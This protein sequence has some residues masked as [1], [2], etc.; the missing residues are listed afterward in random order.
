MKRA[1]YSN[2][3]KEFLK[4]DEL[5]I[6]GEIVSNDQ[7]SAQDLQK[8]T[9]KREI[10]ILKRE[11][12]YFESGYI[13]FEYTIPRI[14]NR[15]DNVFIY[16]GIIFLLEFKVGEKT[17]PNYAIEQVTDY[18]LDLNSFHKESHNKLLV[19]ILVSTEAAEEWQEIKEIRKNILETH[20]CNELNIHNY[21]QEIV[22]NYNKDEFNPIEWVN[23]I[24]MPTPTIIQAAQVLYNGHNVK[25]IS[26][27]DASAINLNKTTEEIN[28]IID[29]S[30]VNNRKS[31]CFITGV[32]GAGKTLAG[33]NIA[34]ER[35]KIDKDEHAVFLSGNGPLVDVLREA[36]ARDDVE[37]NKTT[38]KDSLRKAEEFI[39]KI[40]HFKDDAIS[41]NEAPFERV[42]IF[43]EAQRAWDKENLKD[44][45][46]RKKG[47]KN[48][49]MSEPDFLISILDRHKDWAVI[50]CLVGGGQEINKGESEGISG[51][52]EAIRNKYKN[53][54]V[55]IS[56]KIIEEEYLKGKNFN[57]LVK[58]INYIEKENLHLSVSL[59][60]FR[61]EKVSNFVKL[62]LDNDIPNVSELY[63]EIRKDYPIFLTRDINTAKIWIKSK[64][65]GSERYGMIAS[66]GA[67]RLRKYGIWIQN[68]V[69]A[70]KWFL[71]PKNDIR[72]SYFL[73]ETATEFDIQGLELD[74]TIVCWDANLRYNENFEYY[75]FTGDSWK[76]INKEEIR[77]YL[78]NAYRVLL[79]RARQ[80]FI[81]FVPQ[82][83]SE[84]ET[85]QNKFYD[86]VYNY[87]KNIGIEEI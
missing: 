9:W 28:K 84:D 42:V 24:Y 70:E 31:V 67:K 59:R 37:R 11:L 27:N 75:N 55:Y 17:Y 58:D 80:G 76:N 34:I 65:K 47:I 40:H 8:N 45:M 23:S 15:I 6:F 44:F 14:G 74:W 56:D 66:S 30:K 5:T 46:G 1:Y 20:C 69:E 26:R 3:I 61:S 52:F 48:F 68:K 38:K 25:D 32:P 7:F 54:D 57:E 73:E 49:E 12:S 82:G 86:G 78:K 21:I 36:L 39:Q 16:K 53:W 60:S 62:L 19:P 71:N 10:E 72:S 63:K 85:M 22:E 43:E 29:N 4:Q 13:L 41:T 87:L 79:T 51:W 18:A 35:Q 83:D 77:I 2:S 33:L 50:I 81:I 64:A